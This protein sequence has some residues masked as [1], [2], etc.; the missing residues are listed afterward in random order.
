MS[1][2]SQKNNW[3]W[4]SALRAGTYEPLLTAILWVAVILVGLTGIIL[5]ITTLIVAT[6]TCAVIDLVSYLRWVLRRKRFRGYKDETEKTFLEGL[7]AVFL[8]TPTVRLIGKAVKNF[9]T[10]SQEAP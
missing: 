2:V 9:F 6:P 7:F 3:S 8:V 4:R 5:V 1:P 10:K